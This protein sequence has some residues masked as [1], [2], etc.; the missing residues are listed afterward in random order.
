MT[1]VTK[2][3]SPDELIRSRDYAT[4]D[5]L[6]DVV[7]SILSEANK[8]VGDLIAFD[9]FKGCIV[10]RG[11]PPWKNGKAGRWTDTHDKSLTYWLNSRARLKVGVRMVSD[12]VEV[13]AQANAFNPVLD[14]LNG[15]PEWDGT[16]RIDTW[17]AQCFGA[18]DT[19]LIRAYA[20][21]TLIAAVARI[22]KPGEKVDT[23][24]VLESQQGKRKSSTLKALCPDEAWFSDTRIDISNKDSYQVT[25][26][27]WLIEFPELDTLRGK[28]RTQTRA[29]L[30]SSV[31]TFRPS[32]AKHVIDS[33]RQYIV[34]ATTNESEYL[35][36]WERRMWCVACS[37]KSDTE[38]VKA[39]RDQIWAEALKRYSAG[40][41]WWLDEVLEDKSREASKQRVKEDAIDSRVLA[42]MNDVKERRFDHG[43]TTAEVLTGP[44]GFPLERISGPAPARLAASV[45][46]RLGFTQ[47]NH[48]EVRK[49]AGKTER[50]R[51]WRNPTVVGCPHGKTEETCIKCEL[52]LL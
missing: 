10:C 48:P 38:W 33:P 30:S 1:A 2:F 31:D 40:E 20:G 9:E 41:Q 45:M 23:V 5:H 15:L 29:W 7:G 21:K 8:S 46:R 24:L 4:P 36:E 32:H 42:W 28:E 12:A 22:K 14:Y 35:D 44:M 37:S 26:G 19:P 17:L 39:N 16:P 25:Q 11:K 18:A 51:L 34:I 3:P 49:R 52:G 43:V 47:G 50:V 6:G 27:K 13:V